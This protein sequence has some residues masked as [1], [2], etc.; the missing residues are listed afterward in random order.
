MRVKIVLADESVVTYD[1]TEI[2]VD[3]V[4][5]YLMLRPGEYSTTIKT[6]DAIVG[7]D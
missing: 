5:E 6:T 3:H 1:V 7:D 2:E 4:G